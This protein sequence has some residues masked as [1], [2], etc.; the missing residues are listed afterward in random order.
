[1][2]K[3]LSASGGQAVELRELVDLH[4]CGPECRVR[5]EAIDDWR[6][7]RRATPGSP[8]EGERYALRMREEVRGNVKALRELGHFVPTDLG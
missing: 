2:T 4:L 1:V 5:L 6:S 8:A 3:R 7:G